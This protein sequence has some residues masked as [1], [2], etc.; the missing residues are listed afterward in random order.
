MLRE[1]ELVAELHS[2]RHVPG[3]HAL[4]KLRLTR[5]ELF[6]ERVRDDASLG[7]LH[8]RRGDGERGEHARIHGHC[9]FRTPLPLQVSQDRWVWWLN[10]LKRGDGT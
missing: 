2:N 6:G 3:V 9:Q 4:E 7:A 10:K 8:S 1:A 5:E